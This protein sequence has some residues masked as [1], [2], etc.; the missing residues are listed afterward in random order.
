V[1]GAGARLEPHVTLLRGAVVPDG[2]QVS[3]NSSLS[4]GGP[5]ATAAGASGHATAPALRG[6]ASTSSD[7]VLE[8]V[9]AV[10]ADV[11]STAGTLGA[12]EDI[13]QLEGWDSLSAIHVLVALESAFGVTLPSSLFE[14]VNTLRT[15][16]EVVARSLEQR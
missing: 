14:R 5:R 10:A 12:D 16:A 13:K 15:L 3:R 9:R 8:R 7:S 6:S 1:I 11:V 2:V 4:A